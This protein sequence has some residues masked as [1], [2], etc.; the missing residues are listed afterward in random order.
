MPES[1]TT[2]VSATNDLPQEGPTPGGPTP[3]APPTAPVFAPCPPYAPGLPGL[4]G[5]ADP[6]PGNLTYHL[7]LPAGMA[8][9]IV[10]REVAE[11]VL[12]VHDVD[13]LIDPALVL[14]RELV[15][16]ACQFSED[17]QDIHLG[18]RYRAGTLRVT[19][20]DPHPPHPQPRLA[21]ACDERRR[22]ALAHTPDLV[23]AYRGTWGFSAAQAQ[24]QAQAQGSRAGTWT[25]ATLVHTPRNWAA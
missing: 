20:H 8:G 21:A 9:P 3:P 18:L 2:P 5:L 12:D 11:L 22:A 24:A 7:T 17:G 23:S 25:W 4:P 19:V 16:C 1:G 10:A 15:A 13:R 6:A 14:V